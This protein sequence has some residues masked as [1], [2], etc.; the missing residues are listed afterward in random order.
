MSGWGH[1]STITASP[2][3]PSFYVLITPATHSGHEA[4]PGR[5]ALSAGGGRHFITLSGTGVRA[6]LKQ[7]KTNYLD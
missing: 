2:L 3:S 5:A 1:G 7:A 4:G 6:P